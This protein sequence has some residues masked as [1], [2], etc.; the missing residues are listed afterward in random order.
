MFCLHST[1][2]CGP[3]SLLQLG[4]RQKNNEDNDFFL[5]FFFSKQHAPE[6]DGTLVSPSQKLDLDKDIMLASSV[7]TLFLGP[8]RWS[9]NATSGFG[10][11]TQMCQTRELAR[12]MSTGS[13]SSGLCLR[14][15]SKEVVNGSELT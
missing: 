6:R 4:E 1:A 14:P 8:T 9:N 2:I 3:F 11:V 15:S 13:W 7:P 12:E 5:L 10:V